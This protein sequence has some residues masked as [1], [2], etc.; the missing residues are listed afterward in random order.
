M[1]KADEKLP[2]LRDVSSVATVHCDLMLLCLPT[3]R[4]TFLA[5]VLACGLTFLGLL[6]WGFAKL[7]LPQVPQAQWLTLLL[8]C[9]GWVFLFFIPLPLISSTSLWKYLLWGVHPADNLLKAYARHDRCIF[10][11]AFGYVPLLHLLSAIAWVFVI[12]VP[13]GEDRMGLVLMQVIGNVV[14]WLLAVL[15]TAV[16][17]PKPLC[18]R[19]ARG[20]L[21]LIAYFPMLG[22]AV[23]V[24]VYIPFRHLGGASVGLLMPLLLSAYE[25]I[26]TF[27]V[28]RK[29]VARFVTEIETRERYS[30][31]NQ[32]ICVSMAICN[33]HAMAEGARLTLF[34][35]DSL[36][37]DEWTILIPVVCGVLWNIWMRI[38]CLDR[39][40][41]FIS[42]S[43][44]KPNNS[45][46]YLRE[47]SYCMGYARF[48][49]F[50]A[51][52]LTRVC[53][54][55]LQLLSPLG[56]WELPEARPLLLAISAEVTED[57]IAY[58]LWR[59]NVD[60]YP[61]SRFATDQEVEKVSQHLYRRRSSTVVPTPAE[62]EEPLKDLHSLRWKIRAAHDFKYGPSSFSRLPLW[63]H[64]MPVAMAQFHTIL[65]MTI[66]SNG[67]VYMLKI[68]EN[69]GQGSHGVFWWP[70][71][72]GTCPCA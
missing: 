40:L 18:L 70:M 8:R 43:R 53:L 6:L 12:C 72:N 17:G 25:Q 27:L 34:Y 22:A 10:L 32:G 44:W 5:S 7:G 45:T 69:H 57:V 14:I 35:A 19:Y 9:V 58:S 60:L 15:T 52:I 59:A 11:R 67:V 36:R 71:P 56:F 55:R 29:F 49:A 51:V 62:T 23:V 65:A 39:F 54:G 28:T 48:G 1:G 21:F 38:G 20:V 13:I 33:L 30:A 68:C 66:V 64:F 46:K 3:K 41:H 24:S 50:L 4:G 61:E 26:G 37:N 31:T 47:S 42:C 2:T 16:L 63:A